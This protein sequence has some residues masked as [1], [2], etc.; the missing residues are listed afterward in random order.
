M[1]IRVKM[2][3]RAKLLA[4]VLVTSILVLGFIG[5]FIQYRTYKIALNDAQIFAL[6]SA[7]NAASTVKSELE[8]DLGFSRSLAH[9]LYGYYKYDDS[10]RDSIYYDIIKHQIEQNPRYV[11]IW[12]NFEYSAT[13]P[14]YDKNYGRRSVSS[15]MQNGYGQI[16]IEERNVTGDIE[17][18]EYHKA[19]VNNAELISDPYYFKF[20]GVNEIMVTSISAPI[21]RN[22]NFVGLAGVDVT[23]DKFQETITQIRPYNNSQAFLLSNNSTVV[24]HSNE[25]NLGKPFQE[26]YPEIAMEHR[27]PNK[28]QMGISYSFN[29]DFDDE[30]YLVTITPVEV[31]NFTT[32]WSVGVI[33]PMDEIMVE[34]DKSTTYGLLVAA[35]GLIVLTLVLYYVSKI[36]TS[37]ILQT[38]NVLND[39][40]E[41]D[42]DRNKKLKINTGDELEDMA[43]SVNK[44]IEGLNLTESFAREI[45]KGNLDAEFKILGNKDLLGISLIDMQSSLKQ[46][47]HTE[48]ERKQEEQK[49]NWATQGMAKFGDILR[50]NNDNLNELSFNTIRNLVDY[51][52]SNQ[53]GVFIL[54]DNDSDKPFLEMTACYAFD[55][56]KF[57]EKSVEIGEGLVGRC[58]R[59]GKTIFMTDVPENYITISS[60]LG[61]ERP[62]CLIIVPLRYN[63]DVLGVIEMATFKVY[64]K[65]QVEFI[66]KLAES[67]AATI[68]SVRI[69]IRTTELLAKSQQQ[70]EEMQAQEEEM[71]QNMEELQATQE[72]ME[73]KRAEQE[74]LQEDFQKEIML[75]N[76]L[77]NN[78]PDYI[79]FKDESSHFLRISKSMVKLF[80]AKAPEE[81]VGKSDFDFHTKDNAEHFFM[82]EQ[83]IM[84]T[85]QPI[86]DRIAH[87]KYDDGREQWM[88]ATKMPLFNT[89]GEVVGTWGI[90]RVITE[91]KMAEQKVQELEAAVEKLEEQTSGHEGEYQ[92]IVKALDT[93]TFVT[94]YAT[95]GS[96][97]RINEPLQ[98][99]MGK[100]ADEVAGKHHADFFRTK[101]DD[102]ASYQEFWDDLSRGVVRQRVFKGSIG[103][104]RLTLNET[105][106]PVKDSEGNVEKIIAIAVRG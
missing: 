90:S 92:A 76:A 85:Q 43:N 75:L 71:R 20:D 77:M 74:K 88:A 35:L 94:E 27:I 37:P 19:K 13:K 36:I 81:L 33:I 102:D 66:E 28:V 100:T 53:G 9:S 29:W 40:A 54:N 72:E 93:N 45:G 101:A 52:S 1:A 51:T 57:M 24:A 60:G 59:E 104:S 65:Y 21:R 106:S 91:Q 96:I 82:E 70:A 10:T 14:N 103:G 62:R 15:F 44:L 99:I 55:R 73:R 56:R 46:A 83:E 63:D 22:G 8:F 87:E 95:D 50:Q 16:L 49:Q 4:Y 38:T 18:S 30:D 64:D 42:I 98:T 5:A 86:V 25:L 58:F 105:Y 84:R 17:G 32:P 69:N 47:K 11:T 97:I 34:A 23:L 80:N 3:I 61:Q 7:Q 79:Y 26:I 67:I 31:G 2:N 68:A 39:M 78:I 6:S 48:E 41:G 89:H 12:Y